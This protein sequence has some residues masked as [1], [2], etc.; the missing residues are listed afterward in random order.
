MRSRG[1]AATAREWA[2]A[3]EDEG[4]GHNVGVTWAGRER[5]VVHVGV[6]EVRVVVARGCDW[7]QARVE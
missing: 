2:A 1:E 4:L 6:E 5:G 7:A 3:A